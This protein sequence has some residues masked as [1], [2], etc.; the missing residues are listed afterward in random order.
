VETVPD[1]VISTPTDVIIRVTSTGLCGS[2]LHLLEAFDEFME[3]GD[4]LG[5]EAMGI[6]EDVGRNVRALKAGDRVVIPFSISCGLCYMCTGGLQSQCETTQVT[7]YNCGAAIFG[8]SKLYGQIP[9]GQ[10][11]YLRVPFGNS[12]PIRVPEGPK[13][14]RFVFLAD[15]LPTAWQAVQYADTPENGTLVIIGLGPVGNMSARVARQL[16]VQKIIGVDLAPE[17]LEHARTQGITVLDQ[18]EHGDNL[19]DVIRDLTGGRGADAVVDAFG[20]GA[21][22]SSTGEEHLVVLHSAIDAVRRG[23]TISLAGVYGAASEPFP[24]RRIF[25]KQIQLRM[26]RANVWN[27]AP[28]ILRLLTDDD[29][30]GVDDFASHTLPLAEAPDAYAALGK[31]QEG[32]FKV[33]FEP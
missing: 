12:L 2:D 15:L 27:W 33:V 1:P 14:Q 28:S 29:P 18:H 6:V 19:G 20:M 7:E 11:E 9:G 5:H 21:P 23:G 26:G 13:D 17:R 22:G 24:I 31:R 32:T 10:A 4:I 25:D 3:P 8:Y 16:G 30:L